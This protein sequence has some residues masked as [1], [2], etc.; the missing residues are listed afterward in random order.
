LREA[1]LKSIA[2][3]QFD[4]PFLLWARSGSHLAFSIL[5]WFTYFVAFLTFFSETPGMAMFDLKISRI[6]KIS[7]RIG[8]RAAVVRTMGLLLEVVTLGFGLLPALISSSGRALHDC[9]S[10][11]MVVRSN[12]QELPILQEVSKIS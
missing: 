3:A 1:I 7:L 11:T 10:D 9:L 2:P 12:L 8:W 6:S 5:F 4:N